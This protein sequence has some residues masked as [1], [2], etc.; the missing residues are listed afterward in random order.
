MAF[1]DILLTLTSYP[2]PTPASV[3]EDAVA[4]A[5]ALGAHLAALACEVHV[6]VPGHFLSGSTANIPGIIAGEMEKSRKSARDMLAAFDVAANKAG[7]LHENILERCATFAVPDLLV[8]YARLRDL[9]I[10]PVPES[11]DQWYA[12]A[13]IFGS[14]RPTLVLPESPRPRPFELGTVAIAWDFSRAAARA[15]SDAMPMLEK[16]SKVRIVTVTNEKKL[17]SKHSA[18][19][20]AK[21]LARH[22]IDVV[23]DKV[24]ADGRRIGEVLE[25]Y[26]VSHRVDVL[27]MGAYGHSRLREFILGGATK[28]LLSKPPLPILFSH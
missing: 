19:A 26:T 16:A 10:V 12:E 27:V 4:I 17:D 9:T 3:A 5:A 11:Y 7:I 8:D 14:G 22:G 23:L 18:E 15:I 25:S 24:D 21:N 6:E 2:D 1:K 20:L 28:S 13:V